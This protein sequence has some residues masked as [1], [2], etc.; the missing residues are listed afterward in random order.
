MLSVW[1]PLHHRQR[2]GVV[3]DVGAA[4]ERREAAVA[5]AD[6][7]LE[8][9]AGQRRGLVGAEVGAGNAQLARL[10]RAVTERGDVVEDAVVA[11]GELVDDV[12]PEDVRV[13][14]RDVAGVGVERLVAGEPAGRAEVR[15]AGG[16]VLLGLF[17]AE[18]AEDPIVVAEV[19]IDAEVAL[20]V[21]Q[22]LDRVGQVVAAEPIGE[23]GHRQQVQQRLADRIDAV[24]RDR[25]CRERIADQ[26]TGRRIHA[27][28]SPGR[29]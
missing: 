17:E 9:H 23:G 27:G 5:D 7:V 13:R 12:A 11:G 20:V 22:R 28:A 19:V 24:G 25:D 1:L 18:A 4:L 2:V 21:V 10:V 15:Q 26:L 14:Q 6:E 29:R 16:Q 8:R 3:V